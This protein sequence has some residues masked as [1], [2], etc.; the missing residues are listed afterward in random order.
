MYIYKRLKSFIHFLGF[1]PNTLFSNIRGLSWFFKDLQTLKKQ[2]RQKPNQEF[3]FAKMYP[4]LNEK[5][6]ESGMA[7]GHYFH[8]DLLIA[9]RIFLRQPSKHVDIASRVDGFVAHVASFR[10]IEV[11]DIRPLSNY[12]S[13][14]HFVQ[15]NLMHLDSQFINYTDSISCLHVIE[16]FGLG[17][18]NDPIDIDGHLKGLDNIYQILKTGGIFYFSTPIGR[19]RIEFNAH[20]VF[21]VSYLLELF[22]PRYDILQFSYVD[23]KGDLHTNIELTKIGINNNF[24]CTFGCGI[25]EMRKK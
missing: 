10:P 1:Y 4:I 24:S 25:F 7:S 19:Q 5:F 6:T 22:S 14:I 3:P 21:D 15:A 16:H 17:R 2:M 20:R 23:D 8:Q 9:Q 11:F 18:Y 13:N 12:I